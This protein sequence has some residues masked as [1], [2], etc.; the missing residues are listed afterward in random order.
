MLCCRLFHQSRCSRHRR[1]RISPACCMLSWAGVAGF[2]PIWQ[3]KRTP[4]CCAVGQIIKRRVRITSVAVF[5]G[6]LPAEPNFCR[7]NLHLLI[8][9]NTKIP[10]R[11][12]P[13]KAHLARTCSGEGASLS[14]W[15][16]SFR[17]GVKDWNWATTVDMCH[18]LHLHTNTILPAHL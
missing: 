15:P 6:I 10:I 8:N 5:T 12:H 3:I 16:P 4:P 17:S 1:S 11:M 2:L 18:V 7:R 9:S 14:R 13:W